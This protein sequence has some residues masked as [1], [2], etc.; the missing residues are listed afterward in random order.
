MKS[1]LTVTRL[2][3]R[4]ARS[5]RSG[6][7]AL[8]IVILVLS[9]ALVSWPRA[10]SGILTSDLQYR[11]A[12]ASAS[13]RDLQSAIDAGGGFGQYF[14]GTPQP[15]DPVW[16]S[17]PAAL[18]RIRAQ[19]P[20]SVHAITEP[21][22]YVGRDGGTGGRGVPASGPPHRPA[23][24][25]YLIALE[26]NPQLKSDAV[27]VDGTWPGSAKDFDGTKPLEVVI[28][29]KAAKLL[30]WS[31]GQTQALGTPGQGT[32]DIKLVGTVKPRDENADYWQ[33]DRTREQAGSEPSTDGDSTTYNG[34][35]GKHTAHLLP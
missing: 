8:G 7:V 14:D 28:A 2:G 5:I 19:M 1:P 23:R 10:T 35:A 4:G 22:R 3:L 18:P 20:P 29:A 21:G 16:A 27:L 33:L 6:L 24:A 32:E 31:I 11:M 26:A 9:A 34:L 13:T 25:S 12:T 17:M 15:N 30:H